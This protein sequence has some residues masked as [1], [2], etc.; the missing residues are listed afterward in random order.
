MKIAHVLTLIMAIL[1]LLLAGI[2]YKRFMGDAVVGKRLAENNCGVCHDM[3]STRKNGKGP[4]LWEVYGRPAGVVDFHFSAAFHNLAVEK[5]FLWDEANLERWLIN[6]VAFIPQTNMAKQTKDH[7]VSFD[8]IQ[9]AE[10]RRDLTA[11]L[12]SLR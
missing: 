11:Y 8:G 4:Y 5:P 2:G 9:S 7:P 3:T 10:N 1:V 6:P 12:K